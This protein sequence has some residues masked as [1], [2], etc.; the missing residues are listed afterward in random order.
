[1]NSPIQAPVTGKECLVSSQS[2]RYAL[3]GF[4]SAFNSRDLGAMSRNWARTEEIAM[5]NPLGGLR[6]G[7][8]EIR[9]VYER[10][11]NGPAKV[12]VEFHDY[13]LHESET[14]FYAVG[15]ERGYLD[16]DGK[17]L[18]LAIRTSRVFRKLDGRWQQVHHHGSIED[19]ALLERY[20]KAVRGEAF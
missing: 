20:Q 5:A 3:V 9:G 12:Y 11:F 16:R 7:W 15:R 8:E 4:Y 14:L 1:M 2:A 6:R 19:P 17:R 13:T 18:D 10:I